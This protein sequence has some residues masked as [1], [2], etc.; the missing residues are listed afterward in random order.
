MKNDFI[1]GVVLILISI[2][3]IGS[4]SASIIN[5]NITTQ[6]TVT[7]A[8]AANS[9]VIPV[10]TS[11]NTSKFVLIDSGANKFYWLER[12][13][14]FAYTWKTYKTPAGSVIINVHYKT[15]NNSWNGTYTITKFSKNK[16]KIVYTSPEVKLYTGHSSEVWYTTSK[17]TPVEYYLKLVKTQIKSDGYFFL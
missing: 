12:G 8:T 13:G 11:L 15:S 4:A 9:V 5:S 2:L 16:L 1:L 7:T 6:K 17:L 14:P 10:K 3:M